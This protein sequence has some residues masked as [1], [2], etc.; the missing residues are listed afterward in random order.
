MKTVRIYLF[1]SLIVIIC[2]ILRMTSC[3]HNANFDD[4][5]EICFERDVL[6]IFRNSCAIAGCHDGTGES[7]LRLTN[8]LTISHSVDPG[9][10]YSSSVYKAIIAT[11][12]ENKMP[13]DQPLS[14]DNRTI[15][16]LWIE[17]GALLTICQ[18]TTGQGSGYVNPLACF[19]RD[20]QPVL[21]SRCANAG[22]HDAVTHQ[23]DY[24][25]SSY[26]TTMMAVTSGK[27]EESK[28]YEVIKFAS[29]EDKMPP[30]S[31]AQLT[32]AEIDSIRAWISY[33]A[34]NQYCGEVCD[35]V[36]PVTFSGTIWPIMQTSCSG[37]HGSTSPSGGV[38]LTDYNSIAVAASDGS[39]LNSLK[40]N[41]VTRMPLG[42]S[43]SACRIRQFEIWIN[44]G[45]LNN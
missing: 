43:F 2:I 44:N 32:F 9:K 36:S 16:R 10:P 30:S 41:N 7:D 27:P 31:N 4:I 12:G 26:S 39:L 23:G 40:G 5:P 34:Q 35:T 1:L 24:I 3:V 21:V 33:G 14:L 28:L 18:D 11:A 20:I 38:S 8:Y 13:P 37:C 15:I 25:F 22:C 45:Y 19:S 42:S 6:P 17:Q 29:G